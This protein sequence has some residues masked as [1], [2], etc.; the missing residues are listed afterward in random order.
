MKAVTP[1]YNAALLIS[2]AKVRT[3]TCKGE[4]FGHLDP[5]RPH[6]FGRGIGI[7][8]KV[9]RL[10]L[11]NF[12]GPLGSRPG[13]EPGAVTPVAAGDHQDQFVHIRH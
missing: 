5:G 3:F 12:D 13:G 1:A 10:P 8:E 6:R 11:D 7:E 4:R 2:R 9:S